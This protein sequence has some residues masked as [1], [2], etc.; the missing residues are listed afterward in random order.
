MYVQAINMIV[1][2]ITFPFVC[3]ESKESVLSQIPRVHNLIVG[4]C[5]NASQPANQ[6]GPLPMSVGK[7]PQ[8]R[9]LRN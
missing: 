2:D 3:A 6:A 9:W 5:D 8:S 4:S 7:P 1:T